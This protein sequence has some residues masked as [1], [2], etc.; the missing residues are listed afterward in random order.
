MTQE[1]ANGK[2]YKTL[3]ELY[4]DQNEVKKAEIRNLFQN[5][6]YSNGSI[7][8]KINETVLDTDIVDALYFS[9][10]IARHS[11]QGY[12]FEPIVANIKTYGL[13]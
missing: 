10:G 6:G 11:K 12:F 9:L 8:R 13:S 3:R 2:T 1:L 7:H 5:L 4:D